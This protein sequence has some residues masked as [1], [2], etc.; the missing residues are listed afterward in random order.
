VT[1]ENGLV[2]EA[3]RHHAWAT[4]QLLAFC[5]VLPEDQLTSP[6]TGTYGGILA[7]FHHIIRADAGYLARLRGVPRS[8]LAINESDDFDVLEAAVE[9]T[10]RL[11]EAF[12]AEPVDPDRVLI[13]DDGAYETHASVLVAQALHHGNAHRE[14]ICSILTGFGMEP[15]DVQVWAYADATGRGRDL[16]SSKG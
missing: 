5:R 16:P 2:L 7:T 10:A 11:W 4:G 6:G 8:A 12:L 9:E 1:R 3:F 13:L 14:Q 15:P